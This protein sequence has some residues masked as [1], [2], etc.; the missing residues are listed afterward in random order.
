MPEEVNAENNCSI[1]KMLCGLIGMS[2]QNFTQN[3][4]ADQSFNAQT[5]R[6]QSTYARTIAA[7][8]ISSA[9]TI[10]TSQIAAIAT[11][12]TNQA[13]EAARIPNS[14]PEVSGENRAGTTPTQVPTNIE[15]STFEWSKIA[16]QLASL[17]TLVSQLKTA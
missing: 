13:I 3:H 17:E 1:E 5:A 4:M 11:I 9:S 12:G 2:M 16:S 7:N 15:Q 10:G 6:D 8:Q 14:I